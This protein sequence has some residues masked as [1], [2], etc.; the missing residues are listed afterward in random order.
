[1]KI[2]VDYFNDKIL[3]VY[4]DDKTK[5]VRK[6]CYFITCGELGTKKI[7]KGKWV[8]LKDN[9]DNLLWE[10]ENGVLKPK[11]GYDVIET[12]EIDIYSYPD[13]WNIKEI[14]K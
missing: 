1:M 10:T 5:D 9:K 14:L 12:T 11:M 3:S 7:P 2:A 13:F 8:Q 4:R 6:N